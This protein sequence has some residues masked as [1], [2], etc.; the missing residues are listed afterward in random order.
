[1]VTKVKN[2]M[3]DG[4]AVNVLDK[5]AVGDGIHDDTVAI[6]AAIDEASTHGG[7]VYAPAGTYLV[8]RQV[9]AGDR[10]YALL[11]NANNVSLRGDGKSTVFKLVGGSAGD[12]TVLSLGQLGDIND[13]KTGITLQDF[14]IDGNWDEVTWDGGDGVSPPYDQN[15][16]SG[17]L[18]EDCHVTN[19]LVKDCGQD[20]FT[21]GSSRRCSLT[22]VTVRDCGKGCFTAFLCQDIVVTGGY[23]INPNSSP[24]LGV[25]KPFYTTSSGGYPAVGFGYAPF[26]EFSSYRSRCIVTG[27]H[28]VINHGDGTRGRGIFQ[29]WDGSDLIASGNYVHN[30]SGS[31]CVEL[32]STQAGSVSFI[33][34][35]NILINEQDGWG[36]SFTAENAKI[37]W[38]N[39]SVTTKGTGLTV[40]DCDV[41]SMSDS[42]FNLAGATAGSFT[43][44]IRGAKTVF[45]QGVS[46]QENATFN[47]ITTTC[48]WTGND[49]PARAGISNVDFVGEITYTTNFAGRA[50]STISAGGY[51]TVDVTGFTGLSYDTLITKAYANSLAIA[52]LDIDII[53][54]VVAADTIRI[55]IYNHTAGDILVGGASWYAEVQ[56]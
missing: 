35:G 16:I 32:S 18:L 8:S 31:T 33:V 53:A 42:T 46:G 20:G 6:Q 26:P 11:I 9:P 22:N 24:D 40:V 25:T 7:S 37:T 27:A 36:N 44:D 52:A 34:D 51:D 13:I 30:I 23:F 54:K 1:M 45:V 15:G 10:N 12:C 17:A 56:D 38:S 55:T 50:G 2:R 14:T 19:V 29:S 41:L 21:L 49:I 5:G 4:A 28:V 47:G 48:Y 3:I 39:N 43:F